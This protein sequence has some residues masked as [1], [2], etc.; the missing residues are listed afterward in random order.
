MKKIVVI[1]LCLFTVVMGIL[2]FPQ[3]ATLDEDCLRIHIRANSN[4]T[5]DQNIKYVVKDVVVDY[6]TPLLSEAK[7]KSEAKRIVLSNFNK[8]KEVADDVLKA[9][10]YSYRSNIVLHREEFPTRQY[11]DIVFEAGEYDALIVNL[12]EGVG[13]NWWCVAY[14]PLCFIGGESNGTNK[15]EYHSKLLE[16]IEQWKECHK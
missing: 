8:I 15:I 13:N 14:P 4:S 12:G 3:R 2:L 6:L 11:D 10:G 5:D 16:I 9:N 7:T 1:V